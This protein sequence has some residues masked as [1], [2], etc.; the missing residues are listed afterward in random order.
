MDIWEDDRGMLIVSDQVP[1]LTMLSPDGRLA[2]RC[3]GAINGAHGIWGDPAGNLFMAE[4]PPQRL[5]RLALI[6]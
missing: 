5:T 2:G 6:D 3:R 1:R 4:L